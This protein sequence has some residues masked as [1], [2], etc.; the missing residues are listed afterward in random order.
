MFVIED[1][2]FVD[3]ASSWRPVYL[4]YQLVFACTVHVLLDVTSWELALYVERSDH[5]Y[6]FFAC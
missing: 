1:D 3:S 6:F 4:C 5:V 2:T